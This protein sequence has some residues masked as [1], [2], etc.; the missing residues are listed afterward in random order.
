MKVDKNFTDAMDHAFQAVHDLSE[1][2]WASVG[3][4]DG[5]YEEVREF[6]RTLFRLM[7]AVMV[8]NVMH[9]FALNQ[10]P[11]FLFMGL[12]DGDTRL[13][14]RCVSVLGDPDEDIQSVFD[15]KLLPTCRAQGFDPGE[16]ASAYHVVGSQE[17]PSI[18][19]MGRAQ[20]AIGGGFSL[21]EALDLTASFAGGP[22][23]TKET[24]TGFMVDPTLDGRLRI[25]S[26]FLL[27]SRTAH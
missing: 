20:D 8:D 5:S 3:S 10:N 7:R 15:N 23:F 18:R 26:W 12:P 4:G 1:M 2:V 17:E 16:C 25:S 27:P 11:G 22:R 24:H 14:L 21:E 9:S 6:Q 13:D 19:D